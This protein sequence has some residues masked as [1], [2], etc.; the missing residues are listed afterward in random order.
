MSVFA[1]SIYESLL[2]EAAVEQILGAPSPLP[3]RLRL[4]LI[5]RARNLASWTAPRMGI[6]RKVTDKS[7]AEANAWLRSERDKAMRERDELER[8]GRQLD[9]TV[10]VIIESEKSRG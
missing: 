7:D 2:N 6:L 10:E 4:F 3:P 1:K 8:V 5:D 9:E